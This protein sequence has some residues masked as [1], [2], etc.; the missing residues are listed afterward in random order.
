MPGGNAA[1]RPS[2]HL[3]RVDRQHD[4]DRIGARK[5]LRAAGGQSRR[6]PASGHSRRRAAI[7]AEA[8]P[9]VPGEQRLGG[10][11]ARARSSLTSALHGDRAQVGDEKVGAAFERRHPPPRRQRRNA[12]RPSRPRKR[13]SPAARPALH[14]SA[15]V[16]RRSS[17]PPSARARR[18][19]GEARA[20]ARRRA[21]GRATKSRPPL[22]AQRG[23]AASRHRREGG[24]PRAVGRTWDMMRRTLACGVRLRN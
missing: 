24:G 20:R 7:G 22:L 3:S 12:A 17:L 21:Q 6:Q 1:E 10:A 4:H 19:A 23:R 13:Q 9:G 11:M 14:P 2:R 5:M 15:R 16:E 8:V 18:F